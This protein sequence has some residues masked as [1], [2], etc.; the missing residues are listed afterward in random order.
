MLLIVFLVV[1]LTPALGNHFALVKVGGI[2]GIVLSV[3]VVLWF[4]VLN[5]VWR[6]RLFDRLFSLEGAG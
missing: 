6:K 1:A 4:A 2:Q 5:V 3:G